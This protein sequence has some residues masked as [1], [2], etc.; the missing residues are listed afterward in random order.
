MLILFQQFI[1]MKNVIKSLWLAFVMVG[2]VSAVLL[3]SDT[4]QRKNTKKAVKSLPEIAILQYSS[5]MLLDKHVAGV[6]DQLAERGYVAPD[7]RNLRLFN[8][9]G[10]LGMANTIAQ[11]IANSP[12]SIVITSSTVM[13]QTFARVNQKF[14][15]FHV[16]GAVTDPYGTG[17]G[18][19]GKNS[20]DHPPYMAGIGTFQ[21]V[22]ATFRIIRELNPQIRKVGVVWNPGE[23]CSDA[24]VR[25]ARAICEELGI[26]LIE[27]IAT[28]PTDVS[29]A[30]RSLFSRGAQAIYIGGDTVANSSIKLIIKLAG[31]AGVPVFTNDH[32]DASSGALF[33]LGADY[34][35]VG[36]FTGDMAADILDGK[37][38]AEIRIE[39]IVPEKLELNLPLLSKLGKPWELS[40]A[41]KEFLEKQDQ[42]NSGNGQIP[43]VTVKK[44]AGEMPSPEKERE[45]SSFNKPDRKDGRPALVGLITLSDSHVI[46][47]AINGIEEGLRLKGFQDGKDFLLKKYSA[48]GEIGHL[49]QIID[50]VVMLKPDVIVTV[51]TPAMM[52][53]VRKVSDIPVVFTV[54]SSPERVGLFGSGRPSNLCGIYDNPQ[55]GKLLNM[56]VRHGNNLKV[57]GTIYDPS[58]V[59]SMISVER[60]RI[61]GKEQGIQILE[62][63]VS[64]LSELDA[65]TQSLISRGAGAILLSADNLINSG[66]T[67]IA[68]IA[69]KEGIPIYVTSM[70]LVKL[71]A[72]GG[73][74]VSYHDWGKQSGEIAA[75]VLAGV[76]PDSLPCAENTRQIIIEPSEKR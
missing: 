9:Q 76:P 25:K 26:E 23:Q 27:A 39:N 19:S 52:A 65:A 66:F 74:G 50:A 6:I 45:A 13:L 1:K 47:E 18:I 61:A 41:V 31:Q 64:A 75:R 33:G 34:Y 8:A 59:N 56:A 46:D 43:D 29:E 38:P 63:P 32:L 51:T 62:V 67:L 21:P 55:M 60:L 53:V 40:K 57:A 73:I 72:A 42:M 7:R 30:T 2:T 5:T 44:P 68:R 70:E 28:S 3:L 49:Q 35:T 4:G 16:F 11:E 69:G 17:A 48:Q 20:S 15:K 54:A 71:G 10:E 14:G 24:C 37:S 36:K 12:V 22:E 58:Q